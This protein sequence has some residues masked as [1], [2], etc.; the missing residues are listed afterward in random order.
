[1][2]PSADGFLIGPHR[3]TL[4]STLISIPLFGRSIH[5][6]ML[7]LVH[8]QKT[9]YN[10]RDAINSR[11]LRGN[12]NTAFFRVILLLAVSISVAASTNSPTPQ[13]RRASFNDGWKFLNQPADGAEEIDFNDSQWR[14]VRLPH[15][16]AIEGPFDS[17]LNPHTGALPISGTGWYRKTFTLPAISKDGSSPSNSM[18]PCRTPSSGLT[19]HKLG[20]RP[21]GYS[22]FAFDLTPYL[23]FGAEKN[24][25]AVRLTPEEHSSRWY[26]GAGIY[27][28]VWLTATAPVHVAHWGTYVTTSEVI[29]R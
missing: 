29:T 9:T 6:L 7:N 13:Q 17:K 21:Y 11:A 2:P 12:M 4:M 5:P 14:D 15:D 10:S 16:W 8:V 27:R 23:H 26:P 18:V 28:N 19:V 20:E 24:V 25:L 3:P 1:M 22:S